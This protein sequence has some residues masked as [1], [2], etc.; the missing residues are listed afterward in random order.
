M[1]VASSTL[2]MRQVE[3]GSKT[4]RLKELAERFAFFQRWSLVDVRRALDEYGHCAH[5]FES[6]PGESAVPHPKR[7]AAEVLGDQTSWEDYYRVTYEI[8]EERHLDEAAKKRRTW[9]PA[10]RDY[11]MAIDEDAPRKLSRHR[12]FL[13]RIER[14]DPE[15]FE[16]TGHTDDEDDEDLESEDLGPLALAP[17]PAPAPSPEPTGRASPSPSVTSTAHSTAASISDDD[18]TA[19]SG[20]QSPL[21]QDSGSVASGGFRCGNQP[22]SQTTEI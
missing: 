11:V 6:R 12:M 18:F 5:A 21:T 19:A 20:P 8:E 10:S 1:G 16:Y 15:T 4:E 3:E 13:E 14:G 7:E 22:V 2:I 9:H 17:A